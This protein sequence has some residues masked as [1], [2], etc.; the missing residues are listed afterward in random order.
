MV[1]IKVSWRRERQR[2]RNGYRNGVERERDDLGLGLCSAD[3]ERREKRERE[4]G[5]EREREREY[6]FLATPFS[7]SLLRVSISAENPKKEALI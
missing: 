7:A 2:V 6:Y 1:R 5:R 3:Y 4:R